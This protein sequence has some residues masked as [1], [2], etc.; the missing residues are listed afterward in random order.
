MK[1]KIP[2]IFGSIERWYSVELHALAREKRELRW[3]ELWFMT[4]D[5]SQCCFHLGPERISRLQH[6]YQNR[7]TNKWSWSLVRSRS[8]NACR[9]MHGKHQCH[10]SN[11]LH[12]SEL[13]PVRVGISPSLV[14]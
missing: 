1:E 14:K 13:G 7:V 11:R 4:K 10:I 3:I 12:I 6:R 8:T 2:A 5:W 9:E